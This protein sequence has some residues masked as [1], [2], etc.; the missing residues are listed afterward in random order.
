MEKATGIFLS[1]AL[2][3]LTACSNVITP[4]QP[5]ATTLLSGASPASPATILP[6]V[7]MSPP[8]TPVTTATPT[9]TPTPIVHVIQSGDTLLGIALDYGVD[10]DRLQSFNNIANPQSLQVGQELIIPTGGDDAAADMPGLLLPTPT[11][12]PFGVRGVAFYETPV[13]SLWCLGEIVN[14]TDVALAN[15]QV[16]VT[17][18]DANGEQAAEADAFAAADIIPLG[19]RSPFSILFTSSPAG[20]TN[21]QVTIIRGEAAGT[22][23]DSYVPVGVVEVAG[24]LSGPQFQVSGIVR[25]ESAEQS[26]G[27]VTVIV[28]TYDDQGLVTGTRQAQIELEEPLAPGARAPFT[29]LFSFHGDEPADFNVVALGRI[30]SE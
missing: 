28:T 11:P 7:T 5:P 3:L 15:V 24:Q 10:V 16:R 21:S 20:W 22:L 14:T 4:T 18:F 25:N 19:G 1:T 17:L 9:V 27:S 12:L 6:P 23:A 26:A 8:F 13:G 29:L 30:P 2:L